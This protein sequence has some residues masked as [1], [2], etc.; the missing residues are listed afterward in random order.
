MW[1]NAARKLRRDDNRIVG[2]AF[3]SANDRIVGGAFADADAGAG[4]GSSL[5]SA[6]PRAEP[7][8]DDVTLFSGDRGLSLSS[9]SSDASGCGTLSS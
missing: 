1:H 5:P 8:G 2:G 9:S 3:A 7:G 4:S 6:L